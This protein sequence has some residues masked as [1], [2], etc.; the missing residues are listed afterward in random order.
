MGW[1]ATH[2]AISLSISFNYATCINH[3]CVVVLS[4]FF[5]TFQQIDTIFLCFVIFIYR[6]RTV[7]SEHEHDIDCTLSRGGVTNDIMQALS[8]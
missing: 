3:S 7:E 6:F 2:G 1:E 5:K 4:P 8:L